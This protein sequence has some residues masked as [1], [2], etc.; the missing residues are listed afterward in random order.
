M[1]EGSVE[2]IACHMDV[3]NDPKNPFIHSDEAARWL[4]L[5]PN[6]TYRG[7]GEALGLQKYDVYNSSG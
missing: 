3:E 6:T 5:Y 4:K 2:D 1:K 7:V